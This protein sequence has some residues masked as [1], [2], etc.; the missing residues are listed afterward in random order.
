MLERVS[1][2]DRQRAVG[3]LDDGEG[4]TATGEAAVELSLRASQADLHG[5]RGAAVEA[6]ESS[7][8]LIRTMGSRQAS[9]DIGTT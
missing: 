7:L 1:K 3:E 8:W 2:R 5:V 9:F 6:A 4:E